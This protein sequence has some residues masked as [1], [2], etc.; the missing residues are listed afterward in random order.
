MQQLVRGSAAWYDALQHDF[1]L[2][3]TRDMVPTQC[4]MVKRAYI[5]R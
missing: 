4:E 5:H 1:D 3:N 2:D